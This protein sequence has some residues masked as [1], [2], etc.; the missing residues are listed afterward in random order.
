MSTETLSVGSTPAKAAL[1]QRVEPILAKTVTILKH[2]SSPRGRADR[3]GL[4][5]IAVGFLVA[6]LLLGAVL[7]AVGYQPT[8]FV[9]ILLNLPV[10]WIGFTTTVK[11]LHDVGRTAWMIPA[12]IG[13][14]LVGTFV[15]G[16]VIATALAVKFGTA[17]LA[18]PAFVGFMFL[19]IALP[20][21]GGLL[22]LHTAPGQPGPN[23]YGSP[24]GDLGFT[25]PVKA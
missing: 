10:L 1:V 17:V 3:R 12:A 11:R 6:Q 24:T 4:F 22:W 18:A 8:L 15:I 9:G 20:A 25:T 5:I 2:A 7:H 19:L 23:A 14:W 16:S 13:F 21:F